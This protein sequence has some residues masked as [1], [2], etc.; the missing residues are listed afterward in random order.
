MTVVAVVL[1][2]AVAAVLR[3]WGIRWGLP[4]ALHNLTYH[5]DEIFQ[6]GAMAQLNSFRLMLDPGFYNYPSGYMNL[7]AIVIRV[8]EGWGMSFDDSGYFLV[9][10]VIVAVLGI[11]TIPLVYSAAAKLYGR[12][13]GI[14]ASLLIAIMPLHIVHSHF[15]TVDVP[16]T[17][18]VTVAILGSAIILGRPSWKT[19]L[20]TGLAVGFAVGT[21]YNAA[22][23]IIP[24]IV[25]HF[26]REDSR[27]F[28]SRLRCRMLWIM[29][30]AVL[31]GFVVSTPGNLLWPDRYWGGFLYE[32]NHVATGHGL[33]FKGRGPGWLDVLTNSLGYGLGVFMLVMTLLSVAC[34]FARNKR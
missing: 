32:M 8:L 29:L 3:L 21:K 2:T 16:A 10:R 9:A 22:L 1:I 7:G 18:W 15:A 24:A 23:V 30:G 6:I 13:A 12:A 31:L 25:A 19:Y 20:W 11:A 34:A 4:D 26:L 27:P 17:L 14:I 33:V 28:V 5:P